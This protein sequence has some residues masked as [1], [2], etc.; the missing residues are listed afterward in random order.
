M[1]VLPHGALDPRS[2]EEIAQAEVGHTNVTP[3]VARW[4]MIGFLLI[5]SSIPVLELLRAV[6][7]D[8]AA[9]TPWMHLIAIPAQVSRGLQSID[10]SQR[11][12]VLERSWGVL[13][14]ANRGVLEG[15][16][17]FEKSLEDESRLASTLRPAAQQFLT[18]LL[19]AG[20]EQAYIGRNGWLYYRPDVE[21]VTGRGFLE[22]EVRQQRVRSTAEWTTAPE[23]DPRP[24][25][26]QLHQELAARG[27]S[28]I[29]AP[30][31]V[32]PTIHPE[33]LAAAASPRP[34]NPDYERFVAALRDAGVGVF[35][36][37][38]IL[39][40]ERQ[41]SGA[42]QYL[43]TDTHWRPEAME[44]VVARLADAV[45]KAVPLAPVTD[46]GYVSA[47]V[48]VSHRGDIFGMLDLPERQPLFP[49]E[50]ATIR[51]V[52]QRDGSAWR[53]RPD[54]D[55]LLLGDSFANIYSLESMGWGTSAG[56]AEHLSRVLGRPVD[57]MI[58]NDAGSFATRE[59]L[60]RADPQRLAPKRVVIY[61]FAAR[62]LAFGDWKR[63]PLEGR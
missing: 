34:Q 55:V 9:L 60:A 17:D 25:I 13:I 32:K 62:E 31:P 27:I 42:S 29:V 44:L 41:T 1:A 14:A 11:R 22:H 37:V 58:Q 49:A 30:V 51:Q 57:R 7:G 50:T 48:D 36:A 21:F 8:T 18:G 53:A 5:C 15:L 28:L 39:D 45:R 63:L 20:N 33:H 54:A 10:Q 16:H 40:Q 38:T 2:R 26:I 56:M 24:A 4:M 61:Q 3:V 23:P 46:P 19:G 59:M 52:R 43:A 6:G 47:P 12:D 35:D